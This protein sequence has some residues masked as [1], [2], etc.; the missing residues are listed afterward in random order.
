MGDPSAVAVTGS[1][2]AR[3]GA[4]VG[5][6]SMLRGRRSCL[7]AAGVGVMAAATAAA[8]AVPPPAGL[9][10]GLD[11][12]PPP[13]PAMERPPLQVFN[14]G[15]TGGDGRRTS[16]RG[17]EVRT[18]CH[19]GEVGDVRMCGAG[20]TVGCG[21]ACFTQHRVQGGHLADDA[22]PTTKPATSNCV[23]RLTD[24]SVIPHLR[25]LTVHCIRRGSRRAQAVHITAGPFRTWHCAERCAHRKTKYAVPAENCAQ[26]LFLSRF[27]HAA[28][29]RLGISFVSPSR[30]TYAGL[31]LSHS[32]P[33]KL[34]QSNCNVQ[35]PA[36]LTVRGLI[37]RWSPRPASPRRPRPLTY[38]GRRGT[39]SPRR[40]APTRAE[41]PPPPV[42]PPADGC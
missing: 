17:G 27:L 38:L 32:G 20:R 31:F 4:F 14:I 26:P 40:C 30:R 24:T 5:G 28:P 9:P 7:L 3:R 25:N 22:P 21:V 6:G 36:R 34:A 41:G 29:L 11:G 35:S 39:L 33:I 1:A 8:A 13:S 42:R 18:G 15:E 16:Q 23:G 12:V 10:S 2:S 19:T 37:R